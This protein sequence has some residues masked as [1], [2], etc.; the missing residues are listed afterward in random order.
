MK[1]CCYCF[2]RAKAQRVIAA[3]NYLWLGKDVSR[4]IYSLS[5]RNDLLQPQ[6]NIFLKLGDSFGE[7]DTLIGH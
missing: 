3:K 2:Q 4:D 6:A 1:S 7:Q 5:T